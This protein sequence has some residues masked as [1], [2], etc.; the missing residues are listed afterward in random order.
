[1]R[2]RFALLGVL[3]LAGLCFAQAARAQG[4]DPKKPLITGK[5]A[6]APPH[7]LSGIWG[8]A[9][10]PGDGIQANGVWSYNDDGKPEHTPPYSELGLKTLEAHKPLFGRRAVLSSLS[11]DPRAICEPLGFPRADFY[12]IR[13]EQFMQNDHE[14]AI[15]YEYE[16]RWRSIW[17]DRDLPKEVPEPRW[18]GYSVGKWEDD[19]TLVVQTVGIIGEPRAWLDETG[20]PISED[21]HIE[22]RFH[23][24]NHDLMEWTVTID[25]P[26]MYTKPWVAMNKFPMRLQ[27]PNFDIWGKYQ[28]EMICSP[29]DIESYN[30]SVGDASSGVDGKK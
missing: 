29:K 15:L 30:E 23:R 27:A 8:P 22:E 17:L 26:K 6:P 7:D 19:T 16:K 18:Y 1:M 25:D 9:R 2:N 12:Q 24:V 11:D 20:R 21:A 13:Y 28:V 4:G 3:A 10:G 14:V 5:E